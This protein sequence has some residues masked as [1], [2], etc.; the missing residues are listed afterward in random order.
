MVWID[1]NPQYGREMKD[2]HPWLVLSPRA[3]NVRTSIVVGLPITSASFNETNP[4]AAV[5]LVG[6]GKNQL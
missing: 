3:F 6:P 4:F 1:Y 2:V 5:K